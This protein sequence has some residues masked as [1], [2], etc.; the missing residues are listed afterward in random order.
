VQGRN[1]TTLPNERTTVAA[2]HDKPSWYQV[3]TQDRTI[4]PELERFL[5]QR[6]GAHTIELDTSHLSLLT[7][8]RAV[9]NLILAAAGR[10]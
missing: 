7:E 9:A 1:L 3:S 8:P 5:A 4:N 10:A 2:W 6:M